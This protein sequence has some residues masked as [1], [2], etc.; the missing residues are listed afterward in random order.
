[1]VQSLVG[2]LIH[3]ANPIPHARKITSRILDS[4]RYMVANNKTWISINDQFKA[5]VSWFLRYAETGNG[6][7]I[8]TPI[9]ETI[10]ID[11]DSSL[12]AGG[13]KSES[14]FYSWIYPETHK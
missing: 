14:A 12:H 9:T 1:M 13:G 6:V 7:S 5:D 8:F 3:L 11:C 2:R 10:T 4:L